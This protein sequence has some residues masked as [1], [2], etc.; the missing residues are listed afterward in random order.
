MSM[1]VLEEHTVLKVISLGCDT[2]TSIKKLKE[3]VICD[4]LYGSGV[5]YSLPLLNNPTN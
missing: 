5:E 2:V 4:L 1:N 3:I